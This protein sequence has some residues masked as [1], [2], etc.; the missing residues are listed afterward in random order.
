MAGPTKKHPEQRRLKQVGIRLD[1]DEIARLRS[2][3]AEGDR[4]MNAEVRRALRKWIADH[5]K[6]HRKQVAR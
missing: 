3:V 6:H 5:R 4:S 1:L 2:L